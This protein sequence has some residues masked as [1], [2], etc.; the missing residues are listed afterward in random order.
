MAI[1]GK[2]K[3]KITY[4]SE[5]FF[6]WVKDEFDE[7]GNMLS[8]TIVSED[9]R[10]KIKHFFI[11]KNAEESYLLST[12]SFFPGIEKK[13]SVTIRLKCPDFSNLISPKTVSPKIIRTILEW[14]FN[15]GHN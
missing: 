5:L 10:F 1:S 6:W 9:Q 3:R 12:G 13:E 11:H 7:A 14:S 15:S 8:I 2:T 4:N